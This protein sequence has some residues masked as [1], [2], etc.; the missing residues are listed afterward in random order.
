MSS[1]AT[2]DL[3]GAHSGSDS[4]RLWEP[5]RFAWS[6]FEGVPAFEAHSQ[7]RPPDATEETTVAHF[8]TTSRTTSR[9]TLGQAKSS[10]VVSVA[11]VK[12]RGACI[13]ET[14]AFLRIDPIVRRR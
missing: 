10:R 14:D 1:E 11:S 3:F 13:A 8:T 6:R 4:L 9:S 12:S 7:V 2:Q 5:S